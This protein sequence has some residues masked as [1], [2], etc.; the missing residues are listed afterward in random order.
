MIGCLPEKLVVHLVLI[1][2]QLCFSGWH[3]VGSVALKNGA[4]ALVFAL[5]R[6]LSASLFMY[7]LV[8]YRGQKIF[9]EDKDRPR[10]LLLG[11]FSF[12]N[13]VGTILA[14]QYIAAVQYAVM[15]PLIPVVATVISVVVGFEVVTL[16]KTMGI[17]CAVGGAIL[18]ETWHTSGDDG[19]DDESSNVLLGTVLVCAQ[20]C[21]MASLIVFQKSLLKRYDTTVLTFSYYIVGTGITVLLACAWY[22]RFDAGDF[23]F[24][25]TLFPWIALAYACIFAT[26]YAYN[27]YSWAGKR[28]S[29]AI[30]TVYN[31]LQ[32]VGTCI[33]SVIFLGSTVTIPQV[34]G[35]LFVMAGLVITVYGRHLEAQAGDV[36]KVEEDKPNSE[37]YLLVHGDEDT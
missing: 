29:P 7:A 12:V 32:P 6:E 23:I 18:V 10:I 9:I 15:Q 20:V 24:H 30:T 14:L 37:E 17:L 34:V 5:Y 3:I 2:I 28:V 4:D 11:V 16:V 35:G 36:D 19:D 27:G 8:K 1:S 21:G 22:V 26:V 25:R 13:V 33:F 31:T